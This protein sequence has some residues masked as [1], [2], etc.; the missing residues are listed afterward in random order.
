MQ[1]FPL[2][3]HNNAIFSSVSPSPGVSSWQDLLMHGS[4]RVAVWL[5][6]TLTVAGNLLVVWGRHAA[7]DDDKVLSLF[8]RNLA[9][10]YHL[11]A[12]TNVGVRIAKVTIVYIFFGGTIK[13]I[14]S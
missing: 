10:T 12:D 4:L 1:Y 5:V 7:T 14:S 6:A 3:Q 11:Y 13:Y 8:I 9:G 2:Y